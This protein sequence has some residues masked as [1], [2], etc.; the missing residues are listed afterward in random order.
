MSK[1]IA[2]RGMD[3]KNIKLV[4]YNPEWEQ[5]FLDDKAILEK[6]L[7][8]LGLNDV[9][10]DHIGSTA[11]PTISH[12]KPVIDI[13]MGFENGTSLIEVYNDF[14]TNGF[15]K[16]SDCKC[17]QAWHVYSCINVCNEASWENLRSRIHLILK[18]E[19]M[20]EKYLLF[21]RYMKEFPDEAKRYVEL[22]QKCLQEN[23]DINQY[24]KSKRDFLDEINA[25][26][27][28]LFEI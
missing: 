14:S 12:A 21:K 25:K 1:L 3:I 22:K 10:I 2:Q 24:T 5:W 18:E 28:M 23:K 13:V 15:N 8:K 9:T 7:A 4:P 27:S 19:R 11:I 16:K 17:S 20:Y 26:A 6:R